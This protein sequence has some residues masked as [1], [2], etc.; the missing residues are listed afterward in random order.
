MQL[1]GYGEDS[2]TFVALKNNLKQIIIQLEG[3]ENVSDVTVLYRPSFGRKTGI[4]E[5]DFII[6]SANKVYFGESKMSMG[7]KASRPIKLKDCQLKRHD[8]MHRIIELWFHSPIDDQALSNLSCIQLGFPVPSIDSTLYK[9]LNSFVNFLSSK[10]IMCPELV[11]VLLVFSDRPIDGGSTST[12]GNFSVIN[13][14]IRDHGE[15]ILPNY[16]NML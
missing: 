11:N 3:S 5:F 1:L 13:M 6:A 2:W 9:N 4:G 10:Y 12:I 14:I 8:A 16:V 7:K 15:I